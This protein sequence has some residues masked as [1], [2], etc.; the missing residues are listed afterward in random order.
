MNELF[1]D[2]IN[3]R[4]YRLIKKLVWHSDDMTSEL[5]KMTKKTAMQ[6]K[7]RT[8]NESHPVSIIAF[9]R[10]SKLPTMRVT[11][12]KE[13]KCCFLDITSTVPSSP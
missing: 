10:T 4:Y 6:V 13:R 12:R 7:D 8:F 9:Y 3:Y 5:N 1:T 11:S 2:P